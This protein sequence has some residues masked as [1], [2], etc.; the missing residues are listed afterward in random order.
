LRRSLELKLAAAVGVEDDARLRV[1]GGDRVR[2]RAGD[3]V[4]AQVIGQGVAD[5]PP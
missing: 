1:P 3:Q 5:D 4:R 2:Q